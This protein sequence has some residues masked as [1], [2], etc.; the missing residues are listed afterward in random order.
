MAHVV[1][2]NFAAGSGRLGAQ[3]AVR[4][5]PGVP[6]TRFAMRR[7]TSRV[8]PRAASRAAVRA[9]SR[10]W[11]RANLRADVDARLAARL[12]PVQADRPL[13]RI[14]PYTLGLEFVPKARMPDRRSL[15]VASVEHG[16]LAVRDD[17]TGKRQA[18]AFLR[19]LI[20]LIHYSRGCQQGCVEEA[21]THSFATGLVEFAQ[22]NPGVWLWFNQLLD[23]LT[24]RAYDY[25]GVVR[26][27]IAH[28]P[29]PPRRF[30]VAGEPVTL[31]AIGAREAG[32]AF[33]WYLYE[34]SEA[35]LYAHLAGANL[36][37]VAVHEV[38]HAVHWYGGVVDG[39]SHRDFVAAQARHWLDFMLRNPGAWRWLAYLLSHEAHQD[40]GAVPRTPLLAA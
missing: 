31:E 15:G 26:G 3:A 2:A 30:M 8:P 39:S 38:T 20:R 29:P 22:R 24:A 28:V 13:I 33:G 17:L 11:P 9:S 12:I 35:R 18:H 7:S 27:S 23:R 16:V 5:S 32:S 14:G 10:A 36:A 4:T 1:P 34:Q 37:V 6:A 25:A 21:Y 19:A 40:G